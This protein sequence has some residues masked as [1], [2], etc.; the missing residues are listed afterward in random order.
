MVGSII[1]SVLSPILLLPSELDISHINNN[2]ISTRTSILMTILEGKIIEK[3]LEHIKLKEENLKNY[4]Q[5]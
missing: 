5:C 3:H 4:H 1:L 2:N